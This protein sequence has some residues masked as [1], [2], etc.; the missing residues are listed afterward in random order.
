MKK[1]FL[2]SFSLM[3][4]FVLSGC[5]KEAEKADEINPTSGGESL[6]ES[7]S[8]T[9]KEAADTNKNP[10]EKLRLDLSSG[11]KI[12]CTYKMSD[13]NGDLEVITYAQGDKYRTEMII[14]GLKNY[15]IFDG[16]STYTWSEGQK[17]GIK[18]SLDCLSDLESED[19][20][21]Q[22]EV[23]VENETEAD[24]AESLKDAKNLK[25]EDYQEADFEI[26]AG[27]EFVDQCDLLEAQQ[28]ML[29]G[30]KQ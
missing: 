4:I 16:E 1:I 24:F 30:F 23:E 7:D 29:E 18:I 17:T 26:P 2:I 22:E 11:K 6:A 9:P 20:G 25:C 19:V 12:K 8:S 5:G 21:A 3:M 10:L 13:E 27:I 28:K 15:S 14:G